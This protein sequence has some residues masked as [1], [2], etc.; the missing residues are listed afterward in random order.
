VPLAMV[1]ANVDPAEIGRGYGIVESLFE[2]A[3]VSL[4]VLLGFCRSRGGFSAALLLLSGSF[5]FA[6]LVGLPLLW[7]AREQR[8]Y[9]NG[10]PERLH[11]LTACG[12]GCGGIFT[13]QTLYGI[14]DSG[15]EALHTC[16]GKRAGSDA[17]V[18]SEERGGAQNGDYAKLMSGEKEEGGDGS[19]SCTPRCS[20]PLCARLV[21]AAVVVVGLIILPVSGALRAREDT[22]TS[23]YTVSE[24]TSVHPSATLTSG[25]VH[26]TFGGAD[27]RSALTQAWASAERS[28]VTWHPNLLPAALA[29]GGVSSGGV[30]LVVGADGPRDADGIS[31]NLNLV[32]EAFRSARLRGDGGHDTRLP[33]LGLAQRVA[34]ALRARLR[35]L[36]LL[37]R[38]RARGHLVRRGRGRRRGPA[39]LRQRVRGPAG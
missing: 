36:R 8:I 33:V 21:I 2:V 32:A 6:A 11:R 5:G 19:T 20:Q 4:S 10:L 18:P 3:E 29:S 15:R 9:G 17:L 12:K 30:Q 14:I 39:R 25:E 1:P 24:E 16:F 35:R 34:Y 23:L 38:N 28:A 22:T 7:V 31:P 13:I 37:R 27:E 26:Q